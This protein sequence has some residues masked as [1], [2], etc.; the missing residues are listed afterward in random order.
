M[1]SQIGEFFTPPVSHPNY[2]DYTSMIMNDYPP[3]PII[4][5][6]SSPNQ[7]PGAAA[8]SF[9]YR[10]QAPFANPHQFYSP[11]PSMFEPSLTQPQLPEPYENPVPHSPPNDQAQKPVCRRQ[12]PTKR[13]D[14]K[15]G[16]FVPPITGTTDV[17][18]W[19]QGLQL[20]DNLLIV[21]VLCCRYCESKTFPDKL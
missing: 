11:M 20:F 3:L 13:P 12:P 1:R 5:G 4:R 19:W 9:D 14:G 21:H 8:N 18:V 17:N 10:P 6:D 7:Y 15:Q 2:S 16:V